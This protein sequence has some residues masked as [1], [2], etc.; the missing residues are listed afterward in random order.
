MLGLEADVGATNLTTDTS[1]E[2]SYGN[3]PPQYFSAGFNYKVKQQRALLLRAGYLV[4]PDTLIY[5]LAGLTNTKGTA[6]VWVS[7]GETTQTLGSSDLTQIGATLGICM[8]TMLNDHVSLKVDFR[9]SVFNRHTYL[10]GAQ[11]NDDTA[12]SAG[13]D[14]GSQTVATAIVWHF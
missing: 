11:I 13:L 4:T 9:S 10:D 1:F 12:I 6:S 5:G 14:T 8:E 2:Y 7:D 3:A